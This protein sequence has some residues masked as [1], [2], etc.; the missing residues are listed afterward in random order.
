MTEIFYDKDGNEIEAVPLNEVQTIQETVSQKEARIAELEEEL[1]KGGD[2]RSERT[3]QLRQLREAREADLKRVTE[4]EESIKTQN[5]QRINSYKKNNISKYAGSN[6]D[7][8]KQ[9]EEEYALINIPE[10]TEEN[11]S[12]RF[13]KAAKVLG[14]FKEATDNNPAFASFS[15]REPFLKGSQG[16]NRDNFTATDKGKA[17]LNF[18][19]IPDDK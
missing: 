12:K 11:I 18:M 7:V 3:E 1:K 5:E 17:V 16:D 13:E 9:L 10:D 4:L 14:L 2:A 15:G 19:G 6:D 8:A